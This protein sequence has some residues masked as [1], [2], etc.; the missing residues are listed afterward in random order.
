MSGK[1]KKLNNEELAKLFARVMCSVT[2]RLGHYGE[3]R[4]AGG[5]LILMGRNEHILDYVYLWDIEA[6]LRE[7]VR[8]LR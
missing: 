8:R 2:L 4:M 6:V 3:F 5:R 1:A 7:E